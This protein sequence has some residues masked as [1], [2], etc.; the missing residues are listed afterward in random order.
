V[1]GYFGF[2]QGF[3]VYT[4]P[5][6]RPIPPTVKLENPT[7]KEVGTDLDI[8]DTSMEFLRVHGK[9]RWFLYVHLMDL[10]E[11]LYDESSALFGTR[12]SDVYDNSILRTNNVLAD[13]F[14]RL[15][16][17]GHWEN[18]MIVIASD[19]GEAFGERGNEGHARK[20][21]RESTEVPFLI[22]FPFKL[23]Q[24]IVL[25]QRTRNVDI[26]PTLLDLLGLPVREGTDGRSFRPEILAAASGRPLPEQPEAAYAHLDQTWGLRSRDPMP[27]VAVA[28]RDYRYV[29]YQDHGG[30]QREQL[31]DRGRDPAELEDLLAEEPEVAERLRALGKVYLEGEPPWTEEP[32]ELQIDEMQLNQLRALGYSLP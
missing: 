30:R 16:R 23:D 27:T 5:V 25:E 18:T 24:G 14:E 6:G 29:V 21:Y 20:V 13:F 3:E 9:N 8:V 22:S 12:Y 10:H 32:A 2:D 31:F 15:K 4:R 26:W 19:H 11:Y 28:E 17:S 7:V 1:E